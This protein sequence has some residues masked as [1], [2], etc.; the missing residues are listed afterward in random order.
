MRRAILIVLDGVG[1]GHAPDAEEFGD[2]G[3]PSTLRHVWEAVDGFDAPN[4]S[5]MGFLEAGG[6]L[7]G[8]NEDGRNPPMAPI[9]GI[10]IDDRP[11]T[12][13]H[14]ATSFGRLRP[15]SKGGK[16]SVTGHWEMMGV[17]VDEP[18]PTYPQGFPIPL[19]KQFEERIGTQTLGNRPASGTEIIAQIG[20]LHM[21]TGFPIVY[22]SADSVFQIACH[23]SVVPVDK[24]YEY[25]LI[26]REICVKPNNV[27]RV[28][29]RPFIG[30]RQAGFTR[31]ERRKDF[32]LAAPPNLIDKIGDVLGIGVVPELFAGRGFRPV[33]RTQSNLAHAEMLWQALASDARFIFANF[34]DFDMLFGHRND[35]AGFARCL[36]SFD[37]QVL[38]PL[39]GKL[40]EDDLL[41]LTADHGNDPTD[42]S[43][44]HSREYVPFAAIRPGKG[45]ENLG[46]LEGFSTC[47]RWVAEH[48]QVPF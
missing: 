12:A 10:P 26:A 19:I 3:Q 33:R 14:W 24:L 30:D 23:E 36:E 22:T 34:E 35:P 47:G 32:P 16:D 43:T 7:E 6:I 8:R 31:T 38:A 37:R 28:I 13:A 40:R 41:I 48:L 4:L 5:A 21:D 29:A 44:D 2:P 1:A 45:R 25:C 15:L 46:D 42:E 18:F 27:Q 39:L 20:P 9:E 17:V 11:S